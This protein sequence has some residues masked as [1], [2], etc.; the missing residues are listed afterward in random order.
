MMQK[1]VK[2][3]LR[4]PGGKSRAIGQIA[5]QIPANI[6]EFR[7]PFVGGGSVFFAVRSLFGNRLRYAINDIQTDLIYFWKYARDDIQMLVEVVQTF[8]ESYHENGRTLYSFL[9]DE[10]NMR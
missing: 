5:A 9:K 3:P 1:I 6:G 7:E 10:R 8:Y 4:Y 2:S